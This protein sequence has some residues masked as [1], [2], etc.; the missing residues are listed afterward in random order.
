[1]GPDLGLSPHAWGWTDNAREALIGLQRC[2]HTRGGGPPLRQRVEAPP[3]VVPTRV[4]VD[5]SKAERCIVCRPLSPHAWGWT[6][7]HLVLRPGPVRCPHTRGGGPRGARNQRSSQS[8]SPHAWGW[9]VIHPVHQPLHLALSPHAWGWTAILH[10]TLDAAMRCPHTRGGG[11]PYRAVHPSA[12]SVV[13]TRVGVDR[14]G[15][16]VIRRSVS[17]PHTRG[18]GPDLMPCHIVAPLCCPHTRGGGPPGLAKDEL[19][20]IVVPT[21]VGVDRH[22]ENGA[23][24]VTSC[25]HTRGGGPHRAIVDD[26]LRR[27]VPTRVG[28]DRGCLVG[29]FQGAARCPHTRGGGPKPSQIVR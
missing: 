2:P 9:T 23:D 5:R 20:R 25:P 11:P 26:G 16:S 15:Q 1:M 22:G 29:G 8:L 21:R 6:V 13:P 24:P 7:H 27:V 4:G 17:C 19:L 28:V 18:G 3:I 14:K 12:Y 10:Q